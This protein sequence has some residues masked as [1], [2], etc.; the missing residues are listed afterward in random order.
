MPTR[1]EVGLAWARTIQL[2]AHEFGYS[3]TAAYIAWLQLTLAKAEVAAC[4]R[5]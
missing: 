3:N 1:R 2:A 5:W 4:G